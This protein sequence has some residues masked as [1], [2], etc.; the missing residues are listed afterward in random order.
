MGFLMLILIVLSQLARKITVQV[1]PILVKRTLT[2][3][4]TGT[5]VTMTLTMTE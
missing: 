3:M 5:A 1:F 2:V 4:V